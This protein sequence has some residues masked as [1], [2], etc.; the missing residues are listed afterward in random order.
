MLQHDRLTRQQVSFTN[1]QKDFIVKTSTL[2]TAYASPGTEV[3][4]AI[5]DQYI[6][7]DGYMAWFKFYHPHLADCL[8]DIRQLTPEALDAWKQGL[9][10]CSDFSESG[11]GQQWATTIDQFIQ[12][13]S[14]G[15]KIILDAIIRTALTYDTNNQH[16]FMLLDVFGGAGFVAEFA[17]RIFGF[18]GT[19]ITGDPSSLM[20]RRALQK[21][22]PAFLQRAQDLVMTR[23]NSIDAVLFAYGTHHIPVE[24]RARSFEEAWRVL[25]P[26]G[27]LVCHDFDQQSSTA[28][29]FDQIVDKY[30]F[31]GHQYDH[32]TQQSIHDLFTGAN[33]EIL[34]IDTINDCFT[35]NG[36]TREETIDAALSFMHGAYGLEKI[37]M[38]DEGK[39]FLW[40]NIQRIFK[41]DIS[42]SAEAREGAQVII[43]RPALVGIGRKPLG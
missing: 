2:D 38:D 1:T 25:K 30:T 3:E 22:L 36:P 8:N 20:V 6:D 42:D 29:W 35:L 26:G 31:T 40:Q 24:E 37:T 5:S 43:N 15:P 27:V 7:L 13:R 23:D 16:N 17:G 19:V 21:G 39:A 10:L 33:F 9:S 41:V 32:F 28:H 11:R 12:V 4:F 18:S 14:T 34:S